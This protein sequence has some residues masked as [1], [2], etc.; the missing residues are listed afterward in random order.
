VRISDNI[1][2][3][4]AEIYRKIRNTLIKFILANISDFNY[5]TNHNFDF[6]EVD[7]FILD[8]LQ[9]NINK[10]NKHYENYDFLSIVNIV[11]NFTIELSS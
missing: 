9:N 2:L 7:C 1:V 6:S 3:Q 4:V 11:N 5:T 8:K 10:I